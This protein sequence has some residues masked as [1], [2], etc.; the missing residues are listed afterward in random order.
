MGSDDKGWEKRP[1][2]GFKMEANQPE[3]GM[4]SGEEK[5]TLLAVREDTRF[6]TTKRRR[7]SRE[8]LF[9]GGLM[10]TEVEEGMTGVGM[11][12]ARTEGWSGG[13]GRGGI[14]GEV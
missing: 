2:M 12:G 4:A 10:H 13:E 5:E 8:M 1:Q 7:G 14:L 9:G 11:E 6:S 3:W